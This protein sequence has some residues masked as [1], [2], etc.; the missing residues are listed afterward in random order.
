MAPSIQ[1]RGSRALHIPHRHQHHGDGLAG[2]QRRI[3]QASGTPTSVTNSRSVTTI[4]ADLRAARPEAAAELAEAVYPELRRLAASCLRGERA[5]HTLQPTA[6]VNE[7][8]LRL[9]GPT[10]VAWQNRAHFFA[11]AATQMRR[12][13]VD[14]ARR[15]H[16]HKR[17]AH[18]SGCP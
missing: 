7:V 11:V 14:H 2:R 9:F 12:I 17:G 13:L 5:G 4:L 15:A 6:L 8:F 1:P 10:R 16:A 3:L 18:K